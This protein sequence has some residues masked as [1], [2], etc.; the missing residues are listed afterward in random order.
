MDLP[1]SKAPNRRD[2]LKGFSAALTLPFLPGAH[3][4]ETDGAV[5]PDTVYELRIYHCNDG[6]LPALL[7]RFKKHEVKIFER[8]NMHPVGFWTST[9]APDAGQTLTYML[10][11]AS[12]A[13]A[14]VNWK[15]FSSDPQWLVVKAET[16]KN[17]ALVAKHDHMFLKL[18][19]FSPVL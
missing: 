18:T 2:A 15:N 7:D 4:P 17:G 6:K 12:R 13:A 16:E 19:S 11:H 14:D 3:K 1:K 8:L 9:D 10:R 5:G